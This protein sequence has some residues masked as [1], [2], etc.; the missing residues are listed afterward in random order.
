MSHSIIKNSFFR[1]FQNSIILKLTRTTTSLKV[2]MY[3]FLINGKLKPR[4]E[5]FNRS[6]L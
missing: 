2:T 3:K 4:L 6:N 1:L 5:N